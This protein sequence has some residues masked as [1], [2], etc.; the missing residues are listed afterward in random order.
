M[1]LTHRCKEII[2]RCLD[3][4][5]WALDALRAEVFLAWAKC[6]GQEATSEQ[7]GLRPRGKGELPK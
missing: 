3:Y 7:P 5:G 1:K 4:T 6:R 2:I